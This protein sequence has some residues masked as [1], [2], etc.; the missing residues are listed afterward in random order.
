MLPSMQT[1]RKYVIKYMYTG[2][3]PHGP[4]GEVSFAFSLIVLIQ[5]NFKGN[6]NMRAPSSPPKYLEN[7]GGGG[8]WW[9]HGSQQKSKTGY[10]NLHFSEIVFLDSCTNIPFLEE[11]VCTC[12]LKRVTILEFE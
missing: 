7:G 5:I 8:E 10:K 4:D 9:V 3:T 1:C 6:R 12:L 2:G 11:I